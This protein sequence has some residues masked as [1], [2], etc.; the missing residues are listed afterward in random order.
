[1]WFAWNAKEV[2]RRIYDHTDHSAAV[3]WID[4]IVSDFADGEMPIEVRRSHRA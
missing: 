2:V 1:M 3:E 4:E